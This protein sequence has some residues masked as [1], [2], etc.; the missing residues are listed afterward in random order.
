M[1]NSV[2]IKA[3]DAA[4]SVETSYTISANGGFEGVLAGRSGEDWLRVELV[5]GRN[6][7][8]RLSGVGPEAVLDTVLTIYDSDG[9]EIAAND[10]IETGVTCR[11]RSGK[12]SRRAGR[13]ECALPLSRSGSVAAWRGPRQITQRHG[14]AGTALR[15]VQA[16]P[17]LPGGH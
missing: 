16:L 15:P 7:D 9:K 8:I 17:P 13:Q 4:A 11:Y 6:Y 3:Q 1:T 14:A 5:A 10:D 2:E 12:K